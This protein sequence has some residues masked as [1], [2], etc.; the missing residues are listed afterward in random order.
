MLCDN[1]DRWNGEGDGKGRSGGRG[2]M[3]ICTPVADSGLP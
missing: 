2:H 3:Y 1:L